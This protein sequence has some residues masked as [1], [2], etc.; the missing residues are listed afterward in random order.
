LNFPLNFSDISLFLAVMTII[1]LVSLEMISSY[2]GKI[3]IL[4]SKKKLKNSAVALTL[5][6]LITATMR[7]ISIVLT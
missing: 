6:F 5:I 2:R 7:I 4:I 3:N 1:L